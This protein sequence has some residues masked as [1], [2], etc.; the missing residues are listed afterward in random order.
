MVPFARR[1]AP[2]LAVALASLL[3]GAALTVGCWTLGGGVGV[4]QTHFTDGHVIGTALGADMLLDG[5]AASLWTDR[6]AW[7]G[8]ARLRPLLWP[9]VAIS[10]VTGP[11]IALTL[12]W[13][14]TPL[15]GVLGGAA[16]AASL[17]ARPWGAAL[18][19]G[20][21]AWA[22]WVRTT[23]PTRAK[24]ELAVAKPPCPAGPPPGSAAA[25]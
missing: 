12:A 1:S 25:A 4:P 8:G 13:A 7:P 20:L 3:L 17:G 6:A 16:L 14:L 10:V 9:V 15:L 21:L 5:D 22:P 23:E 2:I 11:A 19:G 18:T 24:G